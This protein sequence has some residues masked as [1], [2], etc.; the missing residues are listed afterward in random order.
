VGSSHLNALQVKMNERTQANEMCTLV[1]NPKLKWKMKPKYYCFSATGRSIGQPTSR[2][3]RRITTTPK[4]QVQHT[5]GHEIKI[6]I[7][8][9]EK[10][11][12][13]RCTLYGKNI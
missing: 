5:K 6:S 7:D 1:Q 10:L 12:A 3:K 13:Y 2:N 4:A 8:N 11:I 9:C